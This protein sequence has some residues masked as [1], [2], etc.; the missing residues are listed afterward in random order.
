MRCMFKT[1]LQTVSKMDG[2]LES[3]LNKVGEFHLEYDHKVQ[4]LRSHRQ[5]LN[6]ILYL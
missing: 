1:S 2:Y 5:K 3:L 4:P 6:S